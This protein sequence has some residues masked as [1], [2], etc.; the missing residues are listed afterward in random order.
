ETILPE[1]I[2][3]T[4]TPTPAPKPAPKRVAIR[5]SDAPERQAH[6]PAPAPGTRPA[7]A[8]APAPAPAITLAEMSAQLTETLATDKTLSNLDRKLLKLFYSETQYTPVWFEPHPSPKASDPILRMNEKAASLRQSMVELNNHG[9]RAAQYWSAEAENAKSAPTT[10][11]TMGELLY[12]RA[13]LRSAIDLNVGRIDPSKVNSE[14]K[15]TKK[16]FGGWQFLKDMTTGPVFLSPW[17]SLAPQMPAYTKLHDAM[18]RLREINSKGGFIAMTPSK[19]I[20]KLGSTGEVVRELKIRAQAMGYPIANL[21]LNY[22]S[23]LEAAI[24][25]IQ[26]ANLVKATGVLKPTDTATWQF[27]KVSSQERVQEMQIN[28]EKLRWLPNSLEARHIFINLATQKLN[29]VDPNLNMESLREMKVI[30]GKATPQTRTPTFR[31]QMT[32][33]VMNPTWSVPSSIFFRSKIEMLRKL[34]SEQGQYAVDSWFYQN[35]FQILYTQDGQKYTAQP[36][37]INWFAPNE[38]FVNSVTLRQMPR[39]DNALGVVKFLLDNNYSIWLHDTNERHLFANDARM[40]SSGC[41]RL[42]NPKD[43]AEY[44]LGPKGYSRAKLESVLVKPGQLDAKEAWVN[45]TN[46]KLPVYTMSLT[47]NV[48]NDGVLRFTRDLYDQN[49]DVLRALKLAGF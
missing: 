48:G 27:F 15:L 5:P 28:M 4:A 22:D 2:Y 25:D 41:I 23:D 11:W 30:V 45:M 37:Q 12:T 39:Y 16:S 34:S 6:R 33:V 42:E 47:A 29:L 9:L 24:K 20:L 46:E 38:S 43:L 19:T 36:S 1:S 26:K 17:A 10:S 35:G 14:I 3:P 31:N 8:P 7:A 18:K 49:V 40:L 32:Y 21:D 13:L 44:L